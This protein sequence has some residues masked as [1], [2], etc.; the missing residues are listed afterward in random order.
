MRQEKLI[1]ARKDKG[2]S[3]YEMAQIVAM[4]QTTYSRKEIGKSPIKDYEWKK[5]AEVLSVEVDEIKILHSISKK[6]NNLSS[7]NYLLS[8]Y[9]KNSKIALDIIIQYN[10][11]LEKE[12]QALKLENSNLKS[13]IREL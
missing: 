10:I 4:E 11:K 1:Q 2:I 3:Q 13:H 9:F 6:E 12:N 7:N 5:F 8:E